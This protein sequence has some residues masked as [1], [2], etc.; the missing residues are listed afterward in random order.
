MSTFNAEANFCK[1]HINSNEDYYCHYAFGNIEA[2]VLYMSTFVIL[3]LGI[4]DLP[5]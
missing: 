5:C 3:N 2:N 1:E 4:F